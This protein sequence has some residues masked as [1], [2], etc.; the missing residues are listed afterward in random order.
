M[1]QLAQRVGLTNEDAVV[2]ARNAA[3]NTRSTIMSAR[4]AAAAEEMGLTEMGGSSIFE[5]GAASNTASKA[6]LSG[7]M[8]E[9]ASTTDANALKAD[10]PA[11]N[12]M[13][14]TA[15]SAYDMAVKAGTAVKQAFQDAANAAY[16]AAIRAGQ[17]AQ[18]AAA[19]AAKV[20]TDAGVKKVDVF[21]KGPGSGREGAIRSISQSGIEVT[22]IRDVTPMPHNGCR[23]PKQRRV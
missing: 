14:T 5:E 22:S 18:M 23:P 11:I 9:S 20:A 10:E 3:A 19:D 21:V 6:T 16:R 1:M 2:A 8:V 17:S 4:N 15:N 12:A 7:R 13:R